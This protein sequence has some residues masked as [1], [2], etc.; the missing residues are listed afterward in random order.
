MSSDSRLSQRKPRNYVIDQEIAR[1]VGVFS[2]AIHTLERSG[3]VPPDAICTLSAVHDWLLSGPRTALSGF[4][5]TYLE[6]A[7]ESAQAD[8]S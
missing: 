8:Q 4:I 3:D 6:Y 5:T 1:L 7:A 2:E